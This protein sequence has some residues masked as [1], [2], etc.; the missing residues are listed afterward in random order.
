METFQNKSIII[1]RKPGEDK[2]GF[3]TVQIALF[4]ENNPHLKGKIPFKVLEYPKIEKVRIKKL[5]NISYYTAGNDLV[6]N[7]LTELKISLDQ[8]IIT[9]TGKQEF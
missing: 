8:G 9:L 7:D 6:I 5:E 1:S 2:E 3:K 4:E